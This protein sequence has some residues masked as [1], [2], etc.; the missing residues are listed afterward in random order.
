MG[1][2]GGDRRR[3]FF[4]TAEA[5]RVRTHELEDAFDPGRLPARGDVDQDQ[6]ATTFRIAASHGD[7]D[8]AT[9][10]G[11]DHYRWRTR[12]GTHAAQIGAELI[13]RILA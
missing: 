4:E 13:D 8:Q 7:A 5:E 12:K 10:R 1:Q 3:R 2:I 11:T 6:G 9:H